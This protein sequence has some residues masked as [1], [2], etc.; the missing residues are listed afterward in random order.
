MSDRDRPFGV[1]DVARHLASELDSRNQEYALGGAIALGYWGS[2]RGTLDV[3]LTLFQSPD[4]P[5]ELMQ[6][7]QAIGCSFDAVEVTA[8]LKE[9]GFCRAK[10]G[11]FRVDLFLPTNAFYDVARMRRKCVDLEG[12]PV[13]VW[14]AETLAVFKMMFFREKDFVDV[15]QILRN[16]GSGF[17]RDWVRQQLVSICGQRDPRVARWDEI[18]EEWSA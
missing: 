2:P 14:D 1:V 8:F 13:M 9:H 12:Q 7:L 18:S 6:L 4:K 15:T 17:D 3:D 11:E 16:Q 10:L 5:V